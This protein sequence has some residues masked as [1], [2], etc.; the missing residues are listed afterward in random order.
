MADETDDGETDAESPLEEAVSGAVFA[1]TFI[2]GF[3]LMFAGVPFFWVAFPVGFAG[4]LPMALGLVKLYQKRNASEQSG[5]K[6]ETEDA[7]EELRQRY[8][9]GE[10][11]ETEFERRVERLLET[12]SIH[13][14]RKYTERVKTDE[15]TGRVSPDERTRDRE[16]EKESS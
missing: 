14:A 16:R 2:V 3:G 10:L 5:T 8:A 6:S 9:R 4:V 7:L 1:L 11:T 12:E 13:D 15:R